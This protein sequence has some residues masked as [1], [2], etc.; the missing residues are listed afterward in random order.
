MLFHKEHRHGV[1]IVITTLYIIKHN[2]KNHNAQF[3]AQLKNIQNMLKLKILCYYILLEI[4][5]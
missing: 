3:E 5:Y 1:V 2:F 4:N